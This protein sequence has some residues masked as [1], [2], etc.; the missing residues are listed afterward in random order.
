MTMLHR[1]LPRWFNRF[2]IWMQ[3]GEKLGKYAC[4]KTIN[5][6]FPKA[7]IQYSFHRGTFLAPAQEWCFWELG[8]PKHYYLDE[9]YPFF[10]LINQT[11]SPFTFFD[12]GADIG[13]VSALVS[14]HC[15]H[16]KQTIAFEP[17]TGSFSLLNHN[18][19]HCVK[20]GK[21][22]NMAV[23]NFS[24]KADLCARERELGDHEGFIEVNDQGQTTVTSLDN[25]IDVNVTDIAELVVIKIDVE[26][27]EAE[28]V[29]GAS[30]LIQNAG[31]TVIMIEIHPEVLARQNATPELLLDAIDNIRRHTWLV[32]KNNNQI[33]DRAQPLFSQ[34]PTGQYDLIAVSDYQPA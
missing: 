34:I 3:K 25:Y 23:S 1:T 2:V 16:L 28:A 10:D 6:L 12:L 9:F 15:P 22:V 20:N 14:L 32:P 27:Q 11:H 31:K 4:F 33:V 7:V 29:E 21:A 13:T 30:Q 5:R 24:G 26:G 8:G 19:H 18:I 17:N